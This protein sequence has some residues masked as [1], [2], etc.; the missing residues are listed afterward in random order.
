VTTARFEVYETG[1]GWRWR[2][3]AA[4]GRI[5]ASGESFASKRNVCRA[6]ETV[7]QLL[8]HGDHIEVVELPSETAD[9][10]P[11]RAS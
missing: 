8:V 5:L 2:L 3:R 10:L 6:I 1:D 11:H 9:E 4:N 7:E